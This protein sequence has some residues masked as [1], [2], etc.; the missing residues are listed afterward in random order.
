MAILRIG[1]LLRFVCGRKQILLQWS[2]GR[3]K[4]QPK[5][6]MDAPCHANDTIITQKC[7]C[8]IFERLI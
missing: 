5:S 8:I 3:K 2:V 6:L 1:F 7:A 4:K